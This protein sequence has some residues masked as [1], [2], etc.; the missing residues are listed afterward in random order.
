MRHFLASLIMIMVGIVAG[1]AAS[2]SEGLPSGS[3]KPFQLA[4][5]ARAASPGL[6]I[7]VVDPAG[8]LAYPVPVAVEYDSGA[9][10]QAEATA[11]GL[12]VP[13]A[14]G[15]VVRAVTLGG[16]SPQRFDIDAARGNFIVFSR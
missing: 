9:P 5:M 8:T 10:I 4:R 3:A 13:A 14:T 15:R 16:Q 6:H 12:T 1:P 7:R 2:A 11:D